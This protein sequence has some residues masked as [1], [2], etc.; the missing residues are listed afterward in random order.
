[1]IMFKVKDIIEICNAKLLQGNIDKECINFCKDTRVIEKNDVY[2]AIK[3]ENFDGNDFYID[4]IKKGAS[5]CI[6]ERDVEVP[7]E[8]SNVIILV[9]EDSVKCLQELARHKISKFKGKV[10]AIT[11]SVGK[12]S[13]KDMIYSVVSTKYKT[14]RTIGNNNNHIGLPLTVLK[15]KDE[16]VMILE[17]GMN[18]FNE[19]SLLSNIAKPDIAIITNIGTAHIGNLGSRENILKAKLE[20]LEGLKEKGKLIINN[21]NDMLHNY[22]LE[23]KKDNIITIGIDNDSNYVAKDIEYNENNVVFNVDN[24]IIKVNVPSNIFVYNSLVAYTVGKELDI[25]NNLIKEGIENFTLTK[26]RLDIK[27]NKKGVVIIDDTYNAS[28]DS[29][30]ASLQILKNRKEKRKIAVLGD[31]L[32]LGEFSESIHRSI[33]DEVI[34]SNV[35]ILVTIGNDIRY[36]IDE[37][38]NKRYE[39]EIYSFSNYSETYELL[40]K[41]LKKDDV[42]LLKASHGIKLTEVVNHLMK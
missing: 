16:E 20:I 19:I 2:V 4:A 13:T 40:D 33:A 18:N 28:F 29:V 9:V 25:E 27:T 17:M 31:I 3:G 11:G 23:N 12:T 14:L 38:N 30:K 7:E 1:M 8:Y 10:I 36:L 32:E 15:H 39:K 37:L 26:N 34:N 5:V 6:L 22:Y 21:D 41:I 35:D 24:N 42:I